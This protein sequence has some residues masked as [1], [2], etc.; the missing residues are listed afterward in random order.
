MKLKLRC[1]EDEL[2]ELK[3]RVNP[4]QISKSDLLVLNLLPLSTDE[5]VQLFLEVFA[6]K[7]QRKLIVK[8]PLPLSK[9]KEEVI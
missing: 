2:E 6:E 4:D 8:D 7:Q 5:K 1:I 3:K 9:K